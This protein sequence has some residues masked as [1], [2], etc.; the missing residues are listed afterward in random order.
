MWSEVV[1]MKYYFIKEIVY[2][3]KTVIIFFRICQ[4][5]DPA[6]SLH[7]PF[8]PWWKV[9]L[10]MHHGRLWP[11]LV[12]SRDWPGWKRIEEELL[13]EGN[14]MPGGVWQWVKAKSDYCNINK[15]KTSR[16]TS[17]QLQG[18]SVDDNGQCGSLNGDHYCKSDF[19]APGG[20]NARGC[21]AS[22]GRS[23]QVHSFLSCLASTFIS[24]NE[25]C[26]LT[27]ILLFC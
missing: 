22:D 9:P 13:P 8:H 14:T 10:A 4:M 3:Q 11:A 20:W 5:C 19:D 27:I 15:V 23:K 2:W 18:C 1:D 24:V 26:H 6:R 16:N 25:E 12:R 21:I 17:N 7:L